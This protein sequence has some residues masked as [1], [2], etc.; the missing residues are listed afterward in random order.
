EEAAGLPGGA[1][2]EGRRAGR[3]TAA[4]GG[5]TWETRG[6]V[7]P[8]VRPAAGKPPGRVAVPDRT[9]PNDPTRDDR[10]DHDLPAAATAADLPP[11]PRLDG[12]TRP[13]RGR[14]DRHYRRA[15]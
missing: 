9:R 5:W 2:P 13:G 7:R 15:A 4:A 8:A 11:V 6:G 14:G 1:V 3:R 12:V 10:G